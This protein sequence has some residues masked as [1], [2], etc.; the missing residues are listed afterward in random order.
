MHWV[1][2]KMK[3]KERRKKEER[4]KGRKKTL[5]FYPQLYGFSY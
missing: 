2:K 1:E 3:K 4:K 5:P